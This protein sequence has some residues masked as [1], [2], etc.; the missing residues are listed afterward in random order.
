MPDTPTPIVVNASPAQAQLTSAV[1]SFVAAVGVAAGVL[2]YQHASVWIGQAAL[3]AG[4]AITLAAVILG[5]IHIRKAEQQKATMANA[6][7]DA[8]A[9]V[10]P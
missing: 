6:L 1:R 7:P 5:Q 10:K 8:V 4:P 9:V 3:V 2:G